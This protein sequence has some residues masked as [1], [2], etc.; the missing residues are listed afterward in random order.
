[1]Q[2]IDFHTLFFGRSL[3]YQPQCQSTNTM[4]SELA[5]IQKL[6]DGTV[7]YTDH[8]THGRGQQNNTWQ[9][10]AGQNFTFSIV[11]YPGFLQASQQFYL[12]IAI[13]L[14]IYKFLSQYTSNLLKIKWPND[15]FFE[16]KKLGG[17][18]IENTLQQVNI[19]HSIVGI[20]L[21][22]NQIQF[23]Q[24]PNATSLAVITQK[25]YELST[26]L[27]E[28]LVH[29]EQQYL[30]LKTDSWI[31]LHQEY[32]QC[33]YRFD[34]IHPFFSYIEDKIIEGKIIDVEDSGRLIFLQKNKR[35]VFNN[36]EIGFIY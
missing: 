12:N 25:K 10:E 11:L 17:I 8:Q 34:E 9:A 3:I 4:A 1:L 18:L 22:I 6:A 19:E 21:N 32:L 31:T 36:K 24:A 23:E 27:P 33:L 20:G 15:I 2:N 7:I 35:L 14:G 28:L 16:N 30:R 26:I 13:V 5:A 29:L